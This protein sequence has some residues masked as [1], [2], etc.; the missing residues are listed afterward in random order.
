MVATQQDNPG[1]SEADR[2]AI[3]CAS[4][5][6]GL[7]IPLADF[8]DRK[9]GPS[10]VAL[11][12]WRHNLLFLYRS[13]YVMGTRATRPDL[14]QALWILAPGYRVSSKIRFMLFAG[15]WAFLPFAA[16]NAA[17]SLWIRAQFID[18]PPRNIT[19][20]AETDDEADPHWL[21]GFILSM[22]RLGWKEDAVLCTPYT[23]L[24][25]YLAVAE[26]DQSN[27]KRPK[28]N[29]RRDAINRAHMLA[30]RARAAAAKA[31]L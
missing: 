11:T 3:R 17:M 12:P 26:R 4:F 24:L 30:A 8:M 20:A 1:L 28:F 5:V 22:V 6:D 14:L 25:Q 23:R 7:A 29:R 2:T 21:A 27:S 10:V 15:R 16:A 18:L 31:A 9:L 19:A 13:P